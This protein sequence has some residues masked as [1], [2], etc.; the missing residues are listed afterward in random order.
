MWVLTFELR[1]D[2]EKILPLQQQR[3]QLWPL[4]DLTRNAIWEIPLPELHFWIRIKV[5]LKGEYKKKMWAKNKFPFRSQAFTKN[6]QKNIPSLLIFVWLLEDLKSKRQKRLVETV[7]LVSHSIYWQQNGAGNEKG[8]LGGCCFKLGEETPLL[9]KKAEICQEKWNIIN[10]HKTSNSMGANL[11]L[12][13]EG[14]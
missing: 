6:S 7:F 4:L 12:S 11:F 13:Q 1:A 2:C 5:N 9:N 8:R 10:G 14:G 3:Q